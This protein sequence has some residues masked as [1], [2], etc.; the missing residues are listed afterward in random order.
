MGY[1]SEFNDAE[2]MFPYQP[3]HYTDD[4]YIYCHWNHLNLFD[5]NDTK[6]TLIKDPCVSV[7]RILWSPDGNLFGKFSIW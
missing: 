5:S 1:R 3:S 4:I 6:A 2:G 7:K